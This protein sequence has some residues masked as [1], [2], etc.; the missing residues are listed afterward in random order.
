MECAVGD[1]SLVG[2]RPC[3]FNQEELT[4][5]RVARGVFNSLTCITGLVQTRG[6]DMSNLRLSAETD[7]R[8][9]ESLS[10]CNHFR[11]IFLTVLGNGIGDRVNR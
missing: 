11:Y 6:A 2:S 3:L 10:L 1:M 4:V 5:E 9:F 7:A 8:M